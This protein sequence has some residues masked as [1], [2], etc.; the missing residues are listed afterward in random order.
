M[1]AMLL[2][3]VLLF[4]PRSHQVRELDRNA[5]RLAK[6]PKQAGDS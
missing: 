6:R 4:D 2:P 5:A 1:L 3:P